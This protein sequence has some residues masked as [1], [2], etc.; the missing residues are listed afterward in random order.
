MLPSPYGRGAGGEV[1]VWLGLF[2]FCEACSPPHG[3]GVG[4]EVGLGDF[5]FFAWGLYA[6]WNV[7][8]DWFFVV[9]DRKSAGLQTSKIEERAYGIV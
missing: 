6:F 7:E 1:G 3:S 9:S 2:V 4:V 5:L 8:M